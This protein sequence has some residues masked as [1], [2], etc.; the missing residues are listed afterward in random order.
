MFL[1]IFVHGFL[2][3]HESFGSLPVDIKESLSKSGVKSEFLVYPSYE[4]KGNNQRQVQ[5]LMDFIMFNGST[6]KYKNVF[7]FAHSMGGLLATD[8]YRHLYHLSPIPSTE[9]ASLITRMASSFGSYFSNPPSLS[10]H[11]AEEMR[12][13]VNITG[14]IT[15]DTPFF[16]L[17]RNVIL[18][19]GVLKAKDVAKELPSYIPS[20]LRTPIVSMIPD[21]LSMATPIKDISIP[22]STKWI[23]SS[24]GG[25]TPTAIPVID[26]SSP[27]TISGWSHAT[28][29]TALVG[30]TVGLYSTLTPM[31]LASFGA[32]HVIDHALFLEPLTATQSALHERV[33]ILVEQ[34]NSSKLYFNSYFNMIGDRD[35]DSR[36]FCNLAP[37]QYESH[38]IALEAP[39]ADEIAAHVGMFDVQ[40]L[41]SEGYQRLINQITKNLSIALAHI[42]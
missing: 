6:A 13:L 34:H 3:T 38:F 27:A 25:G 10:S 8:A 24:L 28:N 39:F 31:A 26:P 30:A 32:N 12:F 19:T 18:S 7:I 23:K 15:F 33:Q 35:S 22:I 5:K 9:S 4:T 14:I 1:I 42:T 37:P 41:G 16:G 36:V 40:C 11:N 2:G 21:N 20:D 17:H 29:I